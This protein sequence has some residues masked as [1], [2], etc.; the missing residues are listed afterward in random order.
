MGIVMLILVMAGCHPTATT[1]P[2]PEVETRTY[3]LQL[4][5]ADGRPVPYA[6][7][8]MGDPKIAGG[9]FMPDSNGV[10]RVSL[11]DRERITVMTDGFP[12]IMIG[13][14]ELKD[15]ATNVVTIK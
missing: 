13:S 1:T 9:A 4:R 8:V 6:S 3:S 15:T 7:V 5:Y 2:S 10:V 12:P 11:P 14:D